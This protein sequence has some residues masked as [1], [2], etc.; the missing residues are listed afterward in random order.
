[1]VAD[2]YT[3][4]VLTVIAVALVVLALRPLVEPRPAVA[5]GQMDVNIVGLGGRTVLFGP[6]PVECE[7]GCQSRSN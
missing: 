5:S 1:M 2:T 6:L 4:V 3:K 7:R